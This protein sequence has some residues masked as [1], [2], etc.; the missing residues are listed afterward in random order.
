MI[1]TVTLNPA[2]DELLQIDRLHRNGA[3][4]IEDIKKYPGGKGLNVGRAL[5]ILGIKSDQILL[6]GEDAAP[7]FK[8]ELEKEGIDVSAFIHTGETRSSFT[9][10]FQENHF[11]THLK[12]KGNFK[13]VTPLEE[14]VEYLEKNVEKGD[15]IVLSGSVPDGMNKEIYGDIIEKMK[16]KGA[17]TYLDSRGDELQAG[18]DAIP[19]CLKVNLDEFIDFVE[20][21]DNEK[22]NFKEVAIKL[23]AQGISYIIITM[24]SEGSLL[25]DGNEFFFARITDKNE[26]LLPPAFVGSGDAFMAGFLYGLEQGMSTLDSFIEANACGAA[27]IKM[28]IAGQFNPDEIEDLKEMISISIEK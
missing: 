5:N 3:S 11:K 2:I 28:E 22:E 6:I 17:L 13:D 19:F 25:F 23:H 8:R 9:L 12:I 10:N 21:D 15:S 20:E 16:A 7:F 14:A 27:N 18:I 24:G 1:Y 4:N 26:N